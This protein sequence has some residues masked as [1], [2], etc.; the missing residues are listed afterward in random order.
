MSIERALA[1]LAQLD[2]EAQRVRNRLTEIDEQAGR[3][4]IYVA[5]ARD[6]EGVGSRQSSAISSATTASAS[7]SRTL[8]RRTADLAVDLIRAK[9]QPIHTRDLLAQMA[10]LG[11]IVRGQN[12]VANLSGF[13]SRDKAHLVNN[14]TLGW[15]LVE[16]GGDS[17]PND[18]SQGE[19]ATSERA[20]PTAS[21]PAPN[22]ETSERSKTTGEADPFEL[23]SDDAD[24][25]HNMAA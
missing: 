9:G 20:A 11:L 22:L 18:L 6:Y 24:R 8:S 12:P 25:P 10:Q 13:L 3:L 19:D 15:R 17:P 5:V 1:D 23:A 2:A 21:E 4:R 7:D 14:R 16:W